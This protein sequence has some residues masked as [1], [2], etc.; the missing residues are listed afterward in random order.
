MLPQIILIQLVILPCLTLQKI[1]PS[2]AN[3]TDASSY[4]DQRQ[5]GKYNINVNIKDVAFISL[6]PENLSANLGVSYFFFF[7]TIKNNFF[8]FLG[9]WKLLRRLL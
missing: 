2:T 3:K 5:T 1:Q 6:E 9:F 4:Y 8:F 7:F